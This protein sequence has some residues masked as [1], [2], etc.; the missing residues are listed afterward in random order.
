MPLLKNYPDT[1]YFDHK[2]HPVKFLTNHCGEATKA[3][4]TAYDING[5]FVGLTEFTD[6]N[7]AISFARS[8]SPHFCTFDD[9]DR[10]V[11]RVLVTFVGN[12]DYTDKV[13]FLEIDEYF[14]TVPQIE[15][16]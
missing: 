16:D 11:Y 8:D 3:I 5:K 10:S 15:E 12:T 7:R 4:V 14:E 6:V 1:D 9:D 2:L 13:R